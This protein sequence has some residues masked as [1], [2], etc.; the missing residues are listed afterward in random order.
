[1]DEASEKKIGRYEILAEL[2]RGAM[3]IVYK[4][5]DP[6]LDRIVAIKTLRVDLGLPPEH[7][8]D[9][10]KRFYRE[11]M[12]AGRLSHPAI[13]AIH[14]VL[15]IDRTP[16]IVMEYVEGQTLA[17]LI[18]VEGPLELQRAVGLVLQVCGALE[19]AHARG[20][21]HRDI[22]PGNILVAGG[23][24]AK[25]SDFGIARI[26]GNK[27]TQTGTMLGSP[28]YMSPEQVKGVGVDGRSDLFSLGV[29]LYEAL[30]G[31]DPFSGESP[32]TVL[33]KIVHEEPVSLPERNRAVPP[34]LDAVVRRVLAK[35]PERRYSTARA[36]ADALSKATE[37]AVGEATT[38]QEPVAVPQ[39]PPKDRRR[40]AVGIGA[41][42]L[43]VVVVGGAVL[44]GRSPDKG[45]SNAENAPPV[46]TESP[47]PAAGAPPG[48][49]SASAPR[50]KEGEG[51]GGG[52]TQ[53]SGGKAAGGSGATARVP[54]PAQASS[55]KAT[56]RG[57]IRITT[58]N[59]VEVLVDGQLVGRVERNPFVI[60][61]VA[62]GPRVITLRLGPVEQKFRGT[63]G[64]DEPFSLTYMFPA[65]SS[66]APPGKGEPPE[67]KRDP[68]TEKR[69][70][71]AEKRGPGE[72]KW[73]PH[74]TLPKPDPS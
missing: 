17:H 6:H 16:Y 13:V 7:Q 42:C 3:G 61:G 50:K 4:A 10:K 37:P 53:A 15:E 34:V 59:S 24:E 51:R 67:A 40:L 2:G 30:T 11:A 21:V 48:A 18:A 74:Y 20:V 41:G 47:K 70:T 58:N 5:R 60:D 23:R 31:V 54:A 65:E 62:V 35:D 44:W 64:E 39:R 26:S 68:S 46:A 49:G 32:S 1:M 12:A 57:S 19:Y 43:L 63:V 22:K 27:M 9:F 52:S 36:F 73:E 14:D 69:E 56:G 38:F 71:P 72:K 45:K 66:A 33:Y 28:S 25:V 8:E 29:V 55:K